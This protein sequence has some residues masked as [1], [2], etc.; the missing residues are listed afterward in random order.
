MSL[1]RTIALVLFVVGLM[2]LIIPGIPGAEFIRYAIILAIIIFVADLLTGR[3][4]V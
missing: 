2:G 3:R 1:L 4:A